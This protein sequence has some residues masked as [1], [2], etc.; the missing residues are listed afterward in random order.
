MG[1]NQSLPGFPG[2]GENDAKKDEEVRINS[3]YLSIYLSI[4]IYLLY[5]SYSEGQEGKEVGAKRANP[6]WPQEEKGAVCRRKAA[7]WYSYV[8]TVFIKVYPNTRCKLK[9]LKME[10]IKDYLL[11]E[12]EFVQ[13]QERLKPQ[14]EKAQEERTKVDELRGS[15]MNIGTLE[16]IIDDDHAIISTSGL[17]TINTIHHKAVPNTTS[18]SSPLLTRIFSSL[19]RA[20]RIIMRSRLLGLTPLKV[21]ISRR[22]TC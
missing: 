18:P 9:L 8:L 7:K 20:N 14:T 15:P 22:S 13:N 3:I 21:S 1:Q 4:I 16:E 11:M 5:Y 19:V 6:C 2:A 17:P 10:R 12:E